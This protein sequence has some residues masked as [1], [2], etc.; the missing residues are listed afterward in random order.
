MRKRIALMLFMAT[1]AATPAFA[2]KAELGVTFGWVFS[3]GVSGN[4]VTTQ[5][6]IFDRLDPKD[7]VTYSIDLGVYVTPNAQVGFIYSGQPS[8]LQAGGTTTLDIGD[9]RIDTYHGY[10]GYNWGESDA[11][12][13]PY[14]IV[15]FGA[16]N[17]GKVDFRTANG[18]AGTLNSVSRFSSTWGVGVKFYG[19]SN[20]GGRA[21]L[22]WTPAYIK[23]DAA[24]W[25]C[26]PY[27]GCYLVGSAQYA[28]QLSL[29]GGLTFRF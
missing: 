25:W 6:G 13:R 26:D 1:V 9:M 22:R 24:G 29:E 7:A 10:F 11:P 8:K 2:Q 15:G 23:S 21:G 5:S 20:V 4:A 12:M 18:A 17:F 3:D 28:N 19:H 16:T 14:F 27:W